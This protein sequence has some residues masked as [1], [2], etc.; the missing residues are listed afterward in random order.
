VGD[1]PRA[2]P[3]RDRAAARWAIAGL[4]WTIALSLLWLFV[5]SGQSTSVSVS[6]DG[7]TV[8]ESST[9]T[10]VESEGSSV[11]L[12]LAVPVVVAGIAVAA[13][14][15]TRPRGIRFACGGLLMAACLLG[16]ASIGLPYV[17]AAVALFL[18]G[19]LTRQRVPVA[20]A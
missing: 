11:V 2:T 16:A 1:T 5:P 12:V 18:S 13:A 3:P 8:T 19:A 20:E 17:P 6:S 7:T 9:H 4:I 15:A 10:L 14:R